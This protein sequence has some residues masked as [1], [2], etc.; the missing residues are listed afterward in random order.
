MS[1]GEGDG[2]RPNYYAVLGVPKDASVADIK[3]AY[4][5][6]ALENHPDRAPGDAEAEAKFR[7][8]AE[9]Y[10]V[11][12]DE[13]KR[14]RYD[15]ALLLP[16]GLDGSQPP[17]IKLARE[18]FDDV[19]GELFGTR[20]ERARRGRDI[21]YTLTLSLEEAVL[22]SRHTIEFE[23]KGAC[24]TCS[25]SGVKPGGRPP[26]ACQVCQGRGE[27]RDSGF[28]SRRSRCT[29]CDGTGLV[30]VDPCASCGGRGQ[31]T[32]LRS[33][34]VAIAP[35]TAAGAERLLDGLGEPGRF[36]G[37]AGTLRIT[38]NVRPHPWLER[39]GDEI[40]MDLPVSVGEAALGAR[41]DVPTLDGW[42][43]L[44]LPAGTKT[45]AKLRL[46]GR[47]VPVVVNGGTIVRRGDQFVRVVIETPELKPPESPRSGSIPPGGSSTTGPAGK[48]TAGSAAAT[49]PADPG[50]A[51]E[52]GPFSGAHAGSATPGVDDVRDLLNRLEARFE[53]DAALLPRRAALREAARRAAEAQT[54]SPSSPPD[55]SATRGDSPP[56][57]DGTDT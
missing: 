51:S 12:S 8:V 33:F 19:V 15:A 37:E 21:R 2:R 29:R 23:S 40:W 4:R 34:D 6:L 14:A 39:R 56:G 57:P 46:K 13:G 3:K 36:G 50:E 5:K 49:K 35:G 30:H 7:L 44:D 55:P 24:E 11:L 43:T 42:V 28:F 41:V 45:G 52:S 32:T 16:R 25:G 26:V 1:T 17:S 47:G 27:V 22:G 53:A 9:A 10:D 18:I 54:P 31:R 48:P 38:I 20:R